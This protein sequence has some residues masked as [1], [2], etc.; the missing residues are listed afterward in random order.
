MASKDWDL[1]REDVPWFTASSV[2][3][4]GESVPFDSL[5]RID[6]A[7]AAR[8]PRLAALLRRADVTRLET[9]RGA[10]ELLGWDHGSGR[11]G[12]LCEP[13]SVGAAAAPSRGAVP[14]HPDHVA[15]LGAFGGVTERFNEP[16][17]WLLNLNS[18]LVPRFCRVGLEEAYDYYRDACHDHGLAPTVRD[19]DY[20]AFA[21]EANGNT[22]LYHR[23]TG[24]V[25]LFAPDHS[26][27][28]VVP[29]EGCPRYTFYRL[30]GAPTLRDWVE[31]VAAAW[32]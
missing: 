9:K 15:V 29:L 17:S 14:L 19:E 16:D 12:W 30:R 26:F 10:L 6:A 11:R 2:N 13:P 18:A 25:I 21:F 31:T 7:L 28:Y 1:F 3:R 32:S 27:D 20:I 5:G 22:T 4:V 24:D 23:E 8:F